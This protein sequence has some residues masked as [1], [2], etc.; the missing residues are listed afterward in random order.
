[1]VRGLKNHL[2]HCDIVAGMD[3]VNKVKTF[4]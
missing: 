2:I 1:L 3:S 4:A